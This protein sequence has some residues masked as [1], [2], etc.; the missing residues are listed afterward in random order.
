MN[1]GGYIYN[2]LRSAQLSTTTSFD[3]NLQIQNTVKKMGCSPS[4]PNQ[5]NETAVTISSGPTQA[6]PLMTEEQ[7][8]ELEEIDN[9]L[10]RKLDKVSCLSLHLF[11]FIAYNYICIW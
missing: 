10:R 5:V 11:Y 7:R 1:R 6:V 9:S 8:E 3:Y 2:Q 4:G